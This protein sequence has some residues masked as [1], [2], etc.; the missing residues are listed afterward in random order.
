MRMAPAPASAPRLRYG[1]VSTDTEVT[2]R[3]RLVSKPH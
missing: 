1:L 3:A 2:E